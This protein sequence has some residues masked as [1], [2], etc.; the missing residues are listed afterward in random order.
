MKNKLII[1]T[2]QFPVSRD[3]KKNTGYI[4]KQLEAA[5]DGNAVIAH[6]SESSL[7]GYAGIDFEFVGEQD[8]DLLLHSLELIL[9]RC[10]ELEIFSIIGGNHFEVGMKKPLTAYG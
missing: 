1:A 7:C 9:K 3:I 4:L 8:H 6:F 10:R 5:R 2:C